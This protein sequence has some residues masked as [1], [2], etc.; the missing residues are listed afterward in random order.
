MPCG[1]PVQAPPPLGRVEPIAGGATP[2]TTKVSAAYL[3]AAARGA[4]GQAWHRLVDA[5]ADA[6]E[7]N[8]ETSLR[9]ISKTGHTSGADA[10]AGFVLAL[11]ALRRLPAA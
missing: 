4:A 1:R 7:G 10:L 8:L 5:L 2:H 11:E 9:H 3:R 6:N